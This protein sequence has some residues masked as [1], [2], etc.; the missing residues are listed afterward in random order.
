MRW[1]RYA[2]A[3]N[4]LGRWVRGRKA[5]SDRPFRFIAGACLLICGC[6]YTSGELLYLTGLARA[7][8]VDAKFR[9]TE[10]PILI[11]IDDPALRIDWP[12][13]HRYLFD[14][15]AQEL[16]RRE[17][18]KKII[19]RQTVEH[20]RQTLPDFA[21]RGARE[22]GEMTDAHQVMLITVLEFHAQELLTDTVNAARF[23]I[24]V[25]ILNVLEKENPMQVRLWPPTPQGHRIDVSMSGSEAGIAKTK[26]GIVKELT[27]RMA[28]RLAR[29]FYDYRP[30]DFEREE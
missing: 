2:N 13:T 15:L 12:P 11:L 9:L 28:E 22:V 19:P 20:L 8:M 21:Q 16:L 5:A 10:D 17:A 30:G 27:K 4:A 6:T 23:A 29:L 3:G 26:E 18:A 24:T 25:K 1:T 7:P 14:E